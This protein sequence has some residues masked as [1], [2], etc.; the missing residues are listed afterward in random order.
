M[1]VCLR[2]V[3]SNRICL[4]L[5]ADGRQTESRSRGT[6]L[7]TLSAE[8]NAATSTDNPRTRGPGILAL[9]Y[10]ERFCSEKCGSQS[11]DAE[12][13]AMGPFRPH[14]PPSHLLRIRAA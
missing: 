10:R 13:R 11:S 7:R 1:Y 6:E 9:Q 3:R 14:T 8:T 4:R 12:T 2:S 5:R